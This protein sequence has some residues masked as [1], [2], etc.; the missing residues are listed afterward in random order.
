MVGGDLSRGGL[1]GIL[2]R[3]GSVMG[4]SQVPVDVFN[5]GQVFACLGL[6]ELT[7]ALVGP[8]EGQFVSADGEDETLFCFSTRQASDPLSISL[9]FLRNA[10]V[11]AVAPIGSEL[12]AKEPGVQTETELG[13]V[14]PAECPATPSA[15]PVRLTMTDNTFDVDHWADGSTRDN[16]KFWAGSGGYS[17]AALWRD[18]AA[19]LRDLTDAA[20][21]SAQSRPFDLDAPMSSSFRFDW[22]RDYV[23]LDL[24]F[25]LNEHV[26]MQS[27][28]FP[29]VEMLAAIG[30]A[31]A[32][33]TRV[34]PRD[35]LA[36]RYGVWLTR[37]P[38]I[39]T[40]PI[41]GGQSVGFPM[42]R[43]LMRLDW[44][45]QENQARCI[46]DVHEE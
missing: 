29:L 1:E 35:K 32:R 20:W 31:H 22:R 43:F 42:R 9:E 5:P 15:L 30:M 34:D 39:L 6:M 19:I 14:F 26:T 7:E 28:G 17:G 41:L 4:Q 23:P 2:S 27:V 16:V 45:G 24:G 11:R 46:V 36:Y 44:P 3:A 37:L 8:C 10:D 40:R 25:S 12:A 21:T 18:A 13:V 33:P 38:T